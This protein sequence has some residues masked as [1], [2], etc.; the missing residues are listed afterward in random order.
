[1]RDAGSL[2]KARAEW[3]YPARVP[4]RV[5]SDKS[6]RL[7]PPP[8]VQGMGSS[9]GHGLFDELESALIEGF[10]RSALDAP[11]PFALAA[12][13]HFQS[14]VVAVGVVAWTSEHH[15]AHPS[16]AGLAGVLVVTL[17]AIAPQVVD[18]ACAG[19]ADRLSPGPNVHEARVLD[20][21]RAPLTR[22]ERGAALDRPVGLNPDGRA[23]RS[24]RCAV[25]RWR[26]ALQE[27]FMRSK[28]AE[29]VAPPNEQPRF[30]GA[31]LE[32]GDQL[33]HLQEVIRLEEYIGLVSGASH[34]H[35]HHDLPGSR[36]MG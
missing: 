24:T 4:A 29:R 2:D 13:A 34:G 19:I 11:D 17:G 15:V 35:R 12:R 32:G 18:G 3:T 10:T 7:E 21:A 28:V 33:E 31:G 23:P 22:T 27:R 16:A 9:S 6:M 8:P 20:V 1:G 36:A 26:P 25:S 30:I 5:A 14:P